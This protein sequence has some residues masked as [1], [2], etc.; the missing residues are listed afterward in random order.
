MQERVLSVS[1]I[2]IAKN[3]SIRKAV[4]MEEFK[5]ILNLR[6]KLETLIN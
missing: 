3:Y 5:H 2:I 6:K 4:S 1:T